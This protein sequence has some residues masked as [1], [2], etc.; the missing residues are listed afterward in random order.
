MRSTYSVGDAILF[1]EALKNTG[2]KGVVTSPPYNKAFMSRGKSGGSNWNGSKLMRENYTHYED[3]L[4]EGEYVAWQRRFLTAAVDCVGEDGVVV[5]NI[6]RKIKNLREDRREEIL[7]GFPVRQTIIWN[8]GSSNNQG[9]KRPTIMPPTYELIYLIAGDKWRLPVKYLPNFRKWGDVWRITPERGNPHPAPFP[10]TLAERMVK[11]V[12]GPVADPFA[13]SGTV[14]IAAIKLGVPYK[15]NDLSEEY[16]G[17]F[18]S[19]KR[20][21]KREALKEALKKEVA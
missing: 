2:I 8:R 15:L 17:M 1:L 19:R 4:P 16:R 5:Y 11:L 20:T 3:N 12:D 6:G 7:R 13:G 18:N 21:L 9:G 14:G 10:V